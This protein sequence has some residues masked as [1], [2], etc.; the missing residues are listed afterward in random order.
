MAA[1]LRGSIGLKDENLSF[2]EALG[3]AAKSWAG[4]FVIG[5]DFNTSPAALVASGV[6][7]S[8]KVKVLSPDAPGTSRTATGERVIDFFLVSEDIAAGAK[9]VGVVEHTGL[10]PHCPVKLASLLKLAAFRTRYLRKQQPLPSACTFGSK[11]QARGWQDVGQRIR[12]R[13][14]YGGL[15]AAICRRASPLVRGQGRA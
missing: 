4:P 3:A 1:Y 13:K 8:M 7:K 15:R 14:R 2:L 10:A 9:Q 5:A 6:E 11:W 12:R